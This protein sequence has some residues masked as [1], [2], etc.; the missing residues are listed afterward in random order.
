MDTTLIASFS[1]DKSLGPFALCSSPMDQ[2]ELWIK[3][4]WMRTG[5]LVWYDLLWLLFEFFCCWEVLVQYLQLVQTNDFEVY[6]LLSNL[7]IVF[8]PKDLIFQY[9]QFMVK[10]SFLL[11]HFQVYQVIIQ[12]N[13]PLLLL[14]LDFLVQ[15]MVVLDQLPLMIQQRW[16]PIIANH[17]IVMRNHLPY[18]HS[19]H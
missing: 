8:H 15:E 13:Q 11:L 18:K 1:K 7:Q 5:H 12:V 10:Q 19:S 17:P 2:L 6:S 16:G 3:D 4:N 9:L 14:L